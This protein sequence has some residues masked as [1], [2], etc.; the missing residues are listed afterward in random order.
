MVVHGRPISQPQRHRRGLVYVEVDETLTSLRFGGKLLIGLEERSTSLLVDLSA[1]LRRGGGDAY[2]LSSFARTISSRLKF[3]GDPMTRALPL[4]SARFGLP[5]LFRSQLRPALILSIGAMAT[6]NVFAT[7]NTS[8]AMWSSSALEVENLELGKIGVLQ[9]ERAKAENKR[10]RN[11]LNE[12]HRGLGKK[13]HSTARRQEE[14]GLGK[15]G[16]LFM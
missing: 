15:R 3:V 13:I 14:L 5:N 12:W 10:K 8:K 9:T 4:C 1:I 6:L 11:E 16:Q 2:P 7:V